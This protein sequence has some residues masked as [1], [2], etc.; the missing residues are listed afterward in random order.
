MKKDGEE[1]M[2]NDT[3]GV[4]RLATNPQ[5]AN[6]DEKE[7]MTLAERQGRDAELSPI[8]QGRNSAR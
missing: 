1:D 3:K 6:K 5:P 2:T 7:G 4:A 8:I